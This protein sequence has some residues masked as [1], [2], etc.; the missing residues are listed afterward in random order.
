MPKIPATVTILTKNN[1]KTLERALNSVKDFDDL[2]ICDGGSID[3]T[4][5]IAQ[6]FG[7][8]I[9]TQSEEF[10]QDGKIFDFAG[11]RNQTLAAAKHNWIFWLDSDEQAG[12]D[13][14]AAIRQVI[15]ERGEDGGGAFWVNRKYVMAGKIID[16]ASTYPNRQMRFFAKNSME[17]MIKKVHERIK[18]KPGVE[19]EF[20]TTGFMYLPT[21]D[22]L[23]AVRRKWGYQIAV[24]AAQ[25]APMSP[26][27][28]LE[29]FFHCAKVSALWLFRLARDSIFCNGT[30]MPFKFE[31]ERHYFH[32]RLLRAYWRVIKF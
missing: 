11:V 18:L 27:K 15:L 23:M 16:C 13:L 3:E 24:A 32:L 21:E 4:L 12:E 2:V 7:A 10:L 29:A 17:G 25:A 5:A 20:L 1:E 26:R 14:V 22:D 31:M 8:K 9:I 6:K 19:K 28:F 30:K